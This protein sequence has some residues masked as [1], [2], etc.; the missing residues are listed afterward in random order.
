[1]T[2]TDEIV[3]NED[4]DQAVGTILTSRVTLLSGAGGVGKSVVVREITQGVR[5]LVLAPTGVAA[6]NANGSTIHSALRMGFA[7]KDPANDTTNFGYLP[8][9]LSAKIREAEMLVID[10]ISMVRADMLDAIDRRLRTVRG[11]NEPFG[12]LLTVLSGDCYQLPPVLARKGGE[13]DAYVKSGLWRS[14]WW[15]D[16]QVITELMLSRGLSL[17]TLRTPMRQADPDFV[18]AL[19]RAR[20]GKVRQQDL[21]LLNSRVVRRTPAES[22]KLVPLRNLAAEI[23]QGHLDS[24]D[25]PEYTYR[26]KVIYRTPEVAWRGGDDSPP[27]ELTLKPGALV[28]MTSN[29]YRGAGAAKEMLW[30]N[31][32]LGKI[33][34]ADEDGVEV[35]LYHSGE[36]YRLNGGSD[37]DEMTW[38]QALERFDGQNQYIYDLKG[39]A[40][41][42]R[43][44][45]VVDAI[46][47]QIP[48]AVAAAQTIHRAQGLT[49]P[50][51]HLAGD[52]SWLPGLAYVGVSRVRELED[53]T[54]DNPLTPSD[55]GRIEKVQRFVS[56]LKEMTDG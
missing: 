40:Q 44:V 54:L 24:L 7:V 27:T 49:L 25:G 11:I 33:I 34:E 45:S 5:A 36:T 55:F 26:R 51:V 3:L 56:E 21:D 10:E 14:E 32:H 30:A 42:K 15:F 17:A 6:I 16:S 28:S 4:Q 43:I 31:G 9:Y 8:P 1:M 18:T 50:K 39:Q 37:A 2:P 48:V 23:N 38:G 41:Q 53:L 13:R 12:G 20:V 52:F 29:A 19:Q 47:F 22:N 35:E 46:A